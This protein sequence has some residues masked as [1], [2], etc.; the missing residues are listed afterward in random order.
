VAPIVIAVSA[1]TYTYTPVIIAVLP[2]GTVYKLVEA[3]VLR[4]IEAVVE[5]IH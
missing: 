5:R 1:V 4:S 2:V 3:I